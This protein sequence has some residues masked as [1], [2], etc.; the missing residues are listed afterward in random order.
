[1]NGAKGFEERKQSEKPEAEETAAGETFKG[2][3]EGWALGEGLHLPC[4]L[5]TRL[6]SQERTSEVFILEAGQKHLWIFDQGVHPA[7]MLF[8]TTLFCQTKPTHPSL[9][10]STSTAIG[11]GDFSPRLAL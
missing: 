6:E 10:T 4:H 3:L 9:E 2:Y 1:M 5:G 11:M 8:L 7:V